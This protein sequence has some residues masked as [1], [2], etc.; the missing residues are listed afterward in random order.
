MEPDHDLKQAAAE[1]VRRGVLVLAKVNPTVHEVKPVISSGGAKGGYKVSTLSVPKFSGK[2]KDWHPFWN[3]FKET[4]HDSSDFSKLVKLSYLR[5]AMKDESLW[6]Q[7]SRSTDDESYYD[8]AV[9]DL[10]EQF[11]KPRTMH[12][13]YLEDVLNI[14]TIKAVRSSLMAFVSIMRELGWAHQVETNRHLF[15]IHFSYCRVPA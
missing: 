9:A 8:R 12:S 1:V 11:D 6:R 15:Y 7:L 5:E 14:G 4:I 10:Q 3:A 2:L 13:S